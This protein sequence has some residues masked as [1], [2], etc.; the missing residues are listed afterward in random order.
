[1]TNVEG[2][3]YVNERWNGRRRKCETCTENARAEYEDLARR[4][5]KALQAEGD[6]IVTMNSETR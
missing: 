2:G 6:E 1:V 3:G 4:E 5:R